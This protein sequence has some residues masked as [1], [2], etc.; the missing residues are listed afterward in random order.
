VCVC[1]DNDRMEAN[2]RNFFVPTFEVAD[3]RHK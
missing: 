1:T 3:I 2:Y